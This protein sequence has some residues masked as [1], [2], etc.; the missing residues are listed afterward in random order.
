MAAKK[1]K[2]TTRSDTSLES[3][4]LYTFFLDRASESKALYDALTAKGAH[5]E[6]HRDY[7][8]DD[9]DDQVWL[10]EVAAKRWIIISQNQ[11]NELER[12]AIRNA[13]GRAFLIVHGEMKGDEEAVMVAAAL[14]KMLRILKANAVSFIARLY[15][16]RRYF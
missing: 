14:P 11:F 3:L 8:K 16:Q 15:T 10:P 6:M 13:K 7:Y 1:K 5:V 9:E 4:D 2:S 12:Q